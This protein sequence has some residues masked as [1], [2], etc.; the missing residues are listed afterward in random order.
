MN[1]EDG[2]YLEK[3]YIKE[4]NKAKGI[5]LNNYIRIVNSL[6]SDFNLTVSLKLQIYCLGEKDNDHSKYRNVMKEAGLE[7]PTKQQF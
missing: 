6:Q 2:I 4:K 7:Y 5:S 1:I 3:N